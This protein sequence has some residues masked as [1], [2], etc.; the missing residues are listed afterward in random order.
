[1]N[2]GYLAAREGRND[3]AEALLREGLEYAEAQVDKELAIWCLG[4]LAALMLS[5][6][7]AD[8]AARLTGAVRTLR[9]ETGH[10]PFPDQ[11]RLDE[12]TRSALASEL[13]EERLA[14]ALAV[15]QE[16]T[17]EQAVAYAL[18]T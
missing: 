6:G 16:M 3:Q 10:A 5:K 4:E 15:G 17:F 12:Q 9:E 8:R 14:V 2:L 13:G 11:Q 18:Q 1:V 7:D